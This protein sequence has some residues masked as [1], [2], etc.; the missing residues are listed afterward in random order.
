M[1]TLNN[2]DN[3]LVDKLGVLAA[4]AVEDALASGLTWD[5]A[6]MAFGV[7]SKAIAVKAASQAHGQPD[8]YAKLAE[9]RLKYGM[10]HSAEVLRS[11]LG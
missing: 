3:R 8:E 7:A 6:I 10:D 4:K 11:F 9:K 5:Q 1:L 2:M